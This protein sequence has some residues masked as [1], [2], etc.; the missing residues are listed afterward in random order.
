[1]EEELKRLA[2]ELGIT[3]SVE[4]TGLQRDIP[5]QLHRAGLAVLASRWEGM[6]NVV[7]E[8]MACGLPCVATRV[9]GTEELIQPGVNGILVGPDD[10]TELTEALVSLLEQPSVAREYGRAARA[11]VERC[12]S[13]DR[14][15]DL[16][17]ALYD[18]LVS[19]G[20]A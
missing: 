14:I 5:A 9:S 15:M 6:P 20:S 1:M 10:Q 11:I 19:T 16:Y 7:L 17:E 8:A 18:R 3:T 13:Q 4:F 12:Y 2:E